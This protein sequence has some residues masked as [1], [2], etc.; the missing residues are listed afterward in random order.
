MAAI[1]SPPFLLSLPVRESRFLF[2]SPGYC[3]IGRIGLIYIKTGMIFVI[4]V[5][6]AVHVGE[7]IAVTGGIP[8]NLHAVPVNVILLYFCTA[9]ITAHSIQHLNNYLESADAASVR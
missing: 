4:T 9:V 6:I 8:F 2:W 3:F 5:F 7:G 1:S